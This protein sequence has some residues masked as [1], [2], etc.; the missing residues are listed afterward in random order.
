MRSAGEGSVVAKHGHHQRSRQQWVQPPETAPGA[1]VGVERFGQ[2]VGQFAELLRTDPGSV[3]RLVTDGAK[4]LRED[5]A[6]HAAAEK[7]DT[8]LR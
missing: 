8:A 1:V 4:R 3:S 5:K 7:L 2:R 6:F